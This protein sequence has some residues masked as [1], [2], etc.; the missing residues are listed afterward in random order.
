MTDEVCLEAEEAMERAIEHAQHEFSRLRSGKATTA[1]VDGIR[2]DAYGS[3]MPLNQVAT[4]TVP[5]PRLI[6]VQPWD[7][8]TIKDVEKAI[9]KSDL[10][11]NPS[12]DGS[13]IRLAIPQLTEERRKDLVRMVKKLAED[14]RVSVRS[15]RRE[16]NERLKAMVKK[17]EIS[18]DQ[19]H[20]GLDEIQELTNRFVKEIDNLTAKKEAE[21]MEV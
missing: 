12:N 2:V 20:D 11:L 17:G 8:S 19:M 1:L 13:V 10:G 6:V 7:K 3:S 16:A 9:M 5:E 21:L 4:I 14:G 18:E 15:I